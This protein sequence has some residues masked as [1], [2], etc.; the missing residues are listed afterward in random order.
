MGWLLDCSTAVTVNAVVMVEDD[1]EKLNVCMSAEL[2]SIFAAADEAA[3][4]SEGRASV[5]VPPALATIEQL[6]SWL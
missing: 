2:K 5:A 4:K 6:T 3:T 1:T